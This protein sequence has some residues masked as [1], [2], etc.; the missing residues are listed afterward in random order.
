MPVYDRRP[1]SPI[2]YDGSYSLLF[3]KTLDTIT[4]L[5]Y[6]IG[7]GDIYPGPQSRNTWNDFFSFPTSRPSVA[8]P[9]LKENYVDVPGLN[10]SLDFSESLTGFPT[11]Q[12]R[13]GSIQFIID[14]VKDVNW[15]YLYSRIKSYLHGQKAYMFLTDM[16]TTYKYIDS[17]YGD[18]PEV[19]DFSGSYDP[20]YYEGRF[21][22]SDLTSN[23]ENSSWTLNYNV[24]P[25]K[26]YYLETTQDW[27][28]DVFNFDSGIMY[29]EVFKDIPVDGYLNMQISNIVGN[30]PT[31]PEITINAT[32]V[33]EGV[34]G[35]KVRLECA[36][37]GKNFVKIL[38]N[39]THKD[40]DYL[41]IGDSIEGEQNGDDVYTAGSGVI[42]GFR[43]TG[44]V[45]VRF[46]VGV[47]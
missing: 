21:T 22:V 43:G 26:F 41:F 18:L 7:S 28:W 17:E 2:R 10:G 44:T 23:P 5:N 4:E 36:K 6:K 25:Y 39:G 13:T 37:T 16:S 31:V 40:T 19:H 29:P 1:G 27:I 35:M 20:W 15:D 12:N 8:A 33:Y 46:R 42:L 14:N 34:V 30:A 9:P 11:Y 47:M 45:T 3:T 24:K 32:S 38:K